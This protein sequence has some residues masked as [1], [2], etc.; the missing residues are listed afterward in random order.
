[1]DQS[2][3]VLYIIGFQSITNY[4]YHYGSYL[5]SPNALQLASFTTI[6]FFVCY[7]LNQ[8]ITCYI[9]SKLCIYIYI[10][11]TVP[12]FFTIFDCRELIT[13]DKKGGYFYLKVA[14]HKAVHLTSL[15]S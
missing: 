1:M 4:E 9:T 13:I 11:V 3:L 12:I 10:Y 8:N 7:L 2:Y 5:L 14:V 15:L 6:Q